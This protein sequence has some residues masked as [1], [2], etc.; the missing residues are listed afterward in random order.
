LRWPPSS[1]PAAQPATQPP[2]LP[3]KTAAFAAAKTAAEPASSEPAAQ[4]A[5]ERPRAANR[6][7]WHALGGV[8]LG[9]PQRVDELGANRRSSRLTQEVFFSPPV[10]LRGLAFQNYYAAAV[11]VHVRG[12]APPGDP[13]AQSSSWHLAL[14]P[15]QL[16]A[17]PH[18]EDDAQEWHS[19]DLAAPQL[20]PPEILDSVHAMRLTYTQPSPSWADFGARHVS[21]PPLLA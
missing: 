19:V 20:A 6:G 1:Q 5:G 3:P 15:L 8:T 14:G 11:S 21:R 9:E 2:R 7:A 13:D 10:R 18:F 12:R 16:M 17:D 4:M